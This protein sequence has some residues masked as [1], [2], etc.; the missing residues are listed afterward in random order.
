[1]LITIDPGRK[2]CILASDGDMFAWRRS[3]GPEGYG[4]PA[5]QPASPASLWRALEG[6]AL[7]FPGIMGVTPRAALVVIEA[8]SWYG[9]RARGGKGMK[10]SAAGQLGLEH[11]IWRALCAAHGWPYRIA[12]A[13]EW[14]K[15][16]GIVVPK[17]TCP[18][19]ATLAAVEARL[20]ELE[21]VPKG[22]SVPHGGLVDAAGMMLAARVWAAERRS[23]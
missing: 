1:M 11:G 16:A 21:L 6:V 12:S 15:A 18:K 14:R 4:A 3:D 2:G 9:G 5:K 22:C 20:P 17:G 19:A 8:P 13:K 7:D 10:A 23:A